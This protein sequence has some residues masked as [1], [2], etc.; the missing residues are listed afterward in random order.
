MSIGATS[1][2]ASPEARTFTGRSKFQFRSRVV[3]P[4]FERKS[5]RRVGFQTLKKTGIFSFLNAA[6]WAFIMFVP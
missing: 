4:A 2:V 5:L 6:R 1:P 3:N